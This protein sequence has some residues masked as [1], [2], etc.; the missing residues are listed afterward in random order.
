MNLFLSCHM[1]M[2]GFDLYSWQFMGGKLDLNWGSQILYLNFAVLSFHT[3][4]P[5]YCIFRVTMPISHCGGL[6][7]IS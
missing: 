4:Q 5:L 7:E 3:Y 2:P 1:L 6:V